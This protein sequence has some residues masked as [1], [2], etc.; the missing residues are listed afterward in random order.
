M[1]RGQCC[2]TVRWAMVEEWRY[3]NNVFF[4]LLHFD[5]PR[6]MHS[7]NFFYFF[8]FLYCIC[9]FQT[10]FI[11]GRIKVIKKKKDAP[12]VANMHRH[13]D[14]NKETNHVRSLPY[15]ISQTCPQTF[16]TVLIFFCTFNKTPRSQSPSC[17]HCLFT[18]P[19]ALVF[20]RPVCSQ[21]EHSG[22]LSKV[23]KK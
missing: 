4:L 1:F 14:K 13:C 8:S 19:E 5:I 21:V 10:C 12:P 3:I 16:Y 20:Q 17:L 9:L 23:R 11:S 7:F 2:K 18:Q 22:C 6:R 15:N